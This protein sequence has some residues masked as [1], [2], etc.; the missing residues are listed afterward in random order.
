MLFIFLF[1][2]LLAQQRNARTK[3]AVA[4]LGTILL[5]PAGPARRGQPP[6]RPRV[7]QLLG[8]APALARRQRRNF[9][10][11]R[12]GPAGFRAGLWRRAGARPAAPAAGCRTCR[13]QQDVPARSATSARVVGLNLAC[14][15]FPQNAAFIPT[16]NDNADLDSSDEVLDSGEQ[17]LRPFNHERQPI[18]AKGIRQEVRACGRMRISPP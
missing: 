18:L 11:R 9:A 16:A 4:P 1:F 10:V 13:D 5:R 7:R 17:G 6:V 3:R 14:L 15:G 2:F 12:V 8:P